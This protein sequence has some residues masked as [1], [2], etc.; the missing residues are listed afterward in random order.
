ML[1]TSETPGLDVEYEMSQELHLFRLR[2]KWVKHRLWVNLPFLFDNSSAK[3]NSTGKT[4]C[5]ELSH[6]IL[7]CSIQK[8]MTTGQNVL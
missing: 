4:K 7:W 2:S 6:N 8:K 1:S 3:P 5:T